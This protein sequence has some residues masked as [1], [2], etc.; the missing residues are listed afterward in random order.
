MKDFNR[1][2]FP[3]AVFFLMTIFSASHAWSQSATIECTF[4][5]AQQSKPRIYQAAYGRLHQVASAMVRQHPEQSR[6]SIQIPLKKSG[7]Y[8]VGAGDEFQ[9]QGKQRIY[10]QPGKTVQLQLN[11]TAC[12]IL[13]PDPVNTFLLQWHQRIWPLL[14]EHA[15]KQQERSNMTDFNAKLESWLKEWDILPLIPATGDH[16][17]DSNL[18]MITQ[19]DLVFAATSYLTLAKA[20]KEEPTGLHAFYRTIDTK[21]LTKEGGV[22]YHPFGMKMLESLYYLKQ[23][24][25]GKPFAFGLDME[26][27]LEDIQ[28]PVL[29]AE[30]VI[31]A[32]RQLKTKEGLKAL[33]DRY[34]PMINNPAQQRRF[35]ERLAIMTTRLPVQQW[36]VEGFSLP[37]TAGRIVSLQDMKGKIVVVDV[38]ATWCVPCVAEFPSLKQLEH[39]YGKRNVAFVGISMDSEKFRDYWKN[40]VAEK[41]PGSIQLF[42]GPQSPFSKMYKIGGIPRFMIFDSTGKMLFGDAPRASSFELRLLL[43]QLIG[44]Q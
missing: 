7:F 24:L 34:G 2:F 35:K 1:V 13:L 22:E 37:D 23:N 4:S 25:Q 10:L 27:R 39:D 28:H 9:V 29:R 21:K 6:F 14:G 44:K 30:L 42:A 33:K 5:S 38:W 11:D 3:F 19:L 18:Q 12:S 17:L 40:F 36:A 31:E 43:D 41:A 15:R 26:E 32:L 8:Y 20:T 16:A